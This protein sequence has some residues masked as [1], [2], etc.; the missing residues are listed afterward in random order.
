MGTV[1]L[2]HFS[3][4]FHQKTGLTNVRI[5][6]NGAVQFEQS[7][8]VFERSRVVF[9]VNNHA[10]HVSADWF[11]RFQIAR[12][13]VFTKHCHQRGQKAGL[14]MSGRYNV[15]V[16]NQNPLKKH[17]ESRLS[18]WFIVAWIIPPHLFFVNNPSHVD[19]LTR[20]CQGNSPNTAPLPPTI[21]PDFSKGRTPHSIKKN[22][23][24]TKLNLTLLVYSW[25]TR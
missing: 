25:L 8:V 9:P 7:Q 4:I 19:S 13:V 20:T 5:E 17:F 6:F 15:L 2:S 1:N 11:P 12:N 14:T 10:F 22:L 3:T 24:L 18:L 16:A 21:R 23:L